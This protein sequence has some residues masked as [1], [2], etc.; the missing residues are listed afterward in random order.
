MWLWEGAR[1]TPSPIVNCSYASFI[2]L[3]SCC[4]R[5]LVR[6]P[7]TGSCNQ[8]SPSR[9]WNRNEVH[10]LH[11]WFIATAAVWSFLLGFFI[12]LSDPNC[13]E[14]IAIPPPVSFPPI[15]DRL[16]FVAS[17]MLKWPINSWVHSIGRWQI[18]PR[19][20]A[21][22]QASIVEEILLTS[23]L[24]SSMCLE[25]EKRY[26]SLM[27]APLDGPASDSL[28]SDAILGTEP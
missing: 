8:G 18:L 3:S 14:G 10:A 23:I 4:Q 20:L 25:M 21:V 9:Q 2:Q 17:K 1:Q 5:G 11:L 12:Y 26:A 24:A 19:P 7:R 27:S 13:S 15:L 16:S 6:T 28:F 22:C